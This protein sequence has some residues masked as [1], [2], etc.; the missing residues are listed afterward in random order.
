[1]AAAGQTAFQTISVRRMGL[2]V[3]GSAGLRPHRSRRSR[4]QRADQVA[5]FLNDLR[6]SAL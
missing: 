3:Q 5:Y 2:I 1:V 6:P 4:E